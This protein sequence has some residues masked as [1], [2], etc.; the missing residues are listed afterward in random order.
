MARSR[1]TKQ[2]NFV[3]EAIL[4]EIWAD[5]LNGV[6]RYEI[7]QK[8]KSDRYTNKTS[9]LVEGTMVKYIREAHDLCEIELKENRDKMRDVLWQRILSVYEDSIKAHDRQSA[10]KSL[11]MMAKYGGLSPDNENKVKVE[12]K[13]SSVEITFGFNDN[14]TE[15]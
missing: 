5:I 1:Y 3:K 10:L 8:L 4:N 9:M 15:S 6:S 7:M 12:T 2:P 11:E 13:D 14:G